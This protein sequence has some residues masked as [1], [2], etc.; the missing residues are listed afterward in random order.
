M[1]SFFRKNATPFPISQIGDD[2]TSS[3]V[4]Y[5]GVDG[6]LHVRNLPLSLETNSYPFVAL[7]ISEAELVPAK[8]EDCTSAMK[9][10]LESNGMCLLVAKHYIGAKAIWYAYASSNSLL[11]SAFAELR[12]TQPVRWGINRDDGW[13]E[14]KYMLSAARA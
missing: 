5:E 9:R 6:T 4:P 8:F 3:D 11:D 10:Q 12:H 1:F 7:A 14:Y 2:W 13:A